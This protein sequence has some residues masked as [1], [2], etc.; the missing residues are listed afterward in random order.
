MHSWWLRA[1]SVLALGLMGVL[2]GCDSTGPSPGEATTERQAAADTL[3]PSPKDPS[4]VPDSLKQVAPGGTLT[5]P[6]EAVANKPDSTGGNGGV[7]RF[8]SVGVADTTLATV[9][10][11]DTEAVLDAAGASGTVT[12][13]FRPAYGDFVSTEAGSF[14]VT[15]QEGNQPP[16]ATDDS[17][18]TTAGEP[19][20]TDVLANDSDPDGSLDPST[21]EVESGPSNGT[22]TVN[23]D[24][25]I[26]YGPNDGFTGTDSYT[27]SVADDAGVADTAEVTIQVNEDNQPPTA[28]ADE[29]T[30]TAGE[31]VTTDVLA[32]DTDPDGSLDPST[33]EVESAPTTGTTTATDTGTVTYTPENGFT[34]TDSYTYTVADDD[35]AES[36]EATVTIQVNEANQPPTATDDSDMTDED[37]E[38]SDEAPGV[39]GNDTDPDGD[40]LS[41]SQVNGSAGDVGTEI[42]L[43]SEALL[44]LSA[45]GG[46]TYDPNDAFE[47]LGKGD[48]GS[49]SFTYTASDGNEGTDQATVT[50]TINGVNDAP[51]ITSGSSV[52]T[53]E[54]ETSTG[55]EAVA[56]DPDDDALTFS[57]SGGADRSDFD[58]D[59]QDGTLKF[60]SAPNF[61][62]PDDKDSGN[63]YEAVI[64]TADGGGGT[65]TTAVTVTVVDSNDA[66]DL[67]NK[68]LTVTE[69]DS[70]AIP[71]DSLSASDE[72]QDDGPSEL[73]FTV[74]E[75]P[76][77]GQ[78]Y[79][80]DAELSSEDTF[81]KQDLLDEK[82]SYEHEASNVEDDNFKFDLTDDDGVGRTDQVFEI[83]VEQP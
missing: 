15:I 43:D 41:V 17:A 68:G 55:Y 50:V 67:T 8:D 27:Y 13:G 9:T 34:G 61:E 20:T 16:T 44:T 58:I 76:D 54:N 71:T 39:L 56:A 57:L 46:Y 11:N 81:T 2:G 40:D 45:D 48:T 65:D 24:G 78:L 74:K 26:T 25:T 5:M 1:G 51:E 63:D 22:T 33:V 49:D 37:T 12:V 64:Q 7:L 53:E 6:I 10:N 83:T 38:T 59:E 52:E 35:G 31:P 36:N 47:D 14:S 3:R 19:V 66:P 69:M 77:Y 29:D 4:A 82:V 32:N 30:T 75:E 21:V 62:N 72:D 79:R 70:V 28:S 42:T 73:T 23:N 60:A 18:M 80:G